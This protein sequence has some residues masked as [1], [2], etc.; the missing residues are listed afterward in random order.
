MPDRG[1]VA[2][3][4]ERILDMEGAS[5]AV[6]QDE[7]GARRRDVPDFLR[8]HRVAQFRE[9]KAEEP[10]VPAALIGAFHLR[11]VRD[12]V[13]DPPRLSGY[14]EVL[15]RVARIVV[16]RLRDLPPRAGEIAVFVDEI[17]HVADFIR[18]DLNPLDIAEDS[19]IGSAQRVKPRRARRYDGIDVKVT[20]GRDVDPGELPEGGEIADYR[21]RAPAADLPRRDD[22]IEPEGV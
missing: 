5:R 7:I 3:H 22:E 12:R 18:K 1:R 21:D 10:G 13:E 17:G 14:P 16:G 6:G 9:E 4:P 19:R 20:E 15:R 11:E 8:R 2:G